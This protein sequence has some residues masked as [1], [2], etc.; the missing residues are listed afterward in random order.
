[1]SMTYYAV[2]DDPNEL[3]H[4]GIKGMKWG[5]RHDKPRHSGSRRNRSPAYKKA[6]SKLSMLMRHGIKRAEAKWKAYN[7]PKAKEERFMKKAMQQARTG[8]LKYGKLTDDQVRR[9]TDRLALERNAR[10]LG[11][12][13]NPKFGKRLKTAI[14]AGIISGVGAGTGAY[15][16]ERFRGR[17][18]TTADIKR[19]KRMDK[20]NSKMSTQ[21]RKQKRKIAED[22]YNTTAE[23]GERPK[24]YG[25]AARARYLKEVK[26]RNKK[27]EYSA[28]IQKTYDEQQARIR[29]AN[30][31]KLMDDDK[32]VLRKD[33]P[34]FGST[35]VKYLDPNTGKTKY[36]SA[37]SAL[38]AWNTAH[39]NVN[40]YGNAYYN[41]MN[42][43]LA[44]IQADQARNREIA[45][46]D[47]AF[48]EALR[49]KQ[50]QDAARE[51]ARIQREQERQERLEKATSSNQSNKTGRSGP[52][53]VRDA[54]DRAGGY[55]KWRAA[56]DRQNTSTR[57]K[58]KSG[59]KRN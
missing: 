4:F 12:T 8:T 17:G 21:E 54:V 45:R 19:D 49:N 13:E 27:S 40:K 41:S 35:Q 50:R 56:I 14:G 11:S 2:T 9:V 26:E 1:M 24:Y 32:R 55:D 7:S 42:T 22:Y 44:K 34:K 43:S 52:W 46:K 18:R 15:I 53:A 16:E 57:R 20:Y 38:D 58:R 39:E 30:D 47:K 29:A 59:G 48:N 28:N 33:R 6:Q 3:A 5:V 37:V 51:S 23:E 25:S 31:A 36:G 10:Q